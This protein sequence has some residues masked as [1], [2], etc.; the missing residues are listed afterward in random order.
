MNRD[1][2]II[3]CHLSKL[4]AHFILELY[5]DDNVYVWMD[6]VYNDIIIYV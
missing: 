2:L 4:K 6:T 1:G 5:L 3:L